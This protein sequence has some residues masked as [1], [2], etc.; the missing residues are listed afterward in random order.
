MVRG[1]LRLLYAGGRSGEEVV[2][3][4]GGGLV[5]RRGDVEGGARCTT[6]PLALP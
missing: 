6:L 1:A 4:E 5:G 2:P 3:W